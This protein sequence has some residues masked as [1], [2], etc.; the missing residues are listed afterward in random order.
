MSFEREEPHD[1]LAVVDDG[2]TDHIP[3]LTHS[4]REFGGEERVVEGGVRFLQSTP[5]AHFRLTQFTRQSKGDAHGLLLSDMHSLSSL[6]P[7]VYTQSKGSRHPDIA[8]G[9]ERYKIPS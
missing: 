6:W 9:P 5:S 1:L 3:K 7:G 4:E 2:D 8:A